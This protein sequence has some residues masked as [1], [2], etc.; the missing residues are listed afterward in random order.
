M[1]ISILYLQDV[2]FEVTLSIMVP[3]LTSAQNGYKIAHKLSVYIYIYIY[4]LGG[5]RS[6]SMNIINTI[7][8]TIFATF[9]Y[10][11]VTLSSYKIKYYTAIHA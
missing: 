6:K 1:H 9:R 3:E 4:I 8:T 10:H 2:V 7:K 5:K 11:L